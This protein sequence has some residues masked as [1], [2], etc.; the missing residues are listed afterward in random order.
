MTTGGDRVDRVGAEGAA[1]RRLVALDVDGTILGEDGSLSPRVTAAVASAVSS[2]AEVTIAT[3]RNWQSTFPVLHD[4]GLDP[5]YVVCANGALIMRRIQA[6]EVVP[7]HEN[8]ASQGFRQYAIEMFDP[9]EV[10]TIIREH[11]PEAAYL[12]EY[13]DGF[14]RFTKGMDEWNLENAEEVEFE[15][16]Y[17]EPVMRVVVR[18]PEHDEEDFLRIV[19]GIGLKHVTYAIGWTSWLDIAPFGVSKATALE[20]VRLALSY[21][22]DEVVVAGDGRNDIEMFEWA[23]EG[24]G[25]AVAMGQA[26][27][28]VREASTQVTLAVE[29]DGLAVFLEDMVDAEESSIG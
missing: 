16:L 21:R 1:L 13:G 6:G 12:V 11:L 2:G 20:K 9:T 25:I 26:P 28:V 7:E 23:A 22:R 3:G 27:D 29:D 10:L 8:G 24:S 5:E 18:S 14:R 19:E 4:L 15:G 17:A